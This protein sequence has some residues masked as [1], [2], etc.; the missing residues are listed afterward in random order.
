MRRRTR[1]HLFLAERGGHAGEGIVL[2]IWLAAHRGSNPSFSKCLAIAPDLHRF[3]FYR[4]VVVGRSLDLDH[5]GT[6]T[7]TEVDQGAQLGPNARVKGLGCCVVL[8]ASCLASCRGCVEDRPTV[9]DAALLA[10]AAFAPEAAA[11]T[12]DAAPPGLLDEATVLPVVGD[13]GASSCRLSYGPA[14]QPFRG[15]AALSVVGNELRLITND[16]GKPRIYP[17][18]IPATAAPVMP[19]RPL[20]FVGMRWPACEIAGAFVYCQGP[21]GM[22]VRSQAAGGEPKQI[23]KSRPGTRIAAAPVGADHAAVAYLD[24]RRTT[25]GD[26]LQAF[27]VLD[28]GEPMRLSDDGA[29]ATTVS[30]LPRGDEPVALYLDVRTAMVPVHARPV[31]RTPDGALALGTDAVVFVGGAPER[32]IDFTTALAGD[33]AYAFVPMP[34]DTLEF[35]MA[36]V[37]IESPPKDD[38]PARWSLYPNGIDPA[39]ITAAPSRDGKGAWIARVRPRQKEPGSPRII[40]LGRVD[41]AG[42][43]ASYGEI[44]LAKAVTDIALV[45]DA[46]GGVWVTYGDTTVTWLERRIC[47]TVSANKNG[48]FPRPAR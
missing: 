32:G 47:S 23:A 7:V 45:E 11:P 26:M 31:R 18:P 38:V 36:T 22:I 42:L 13:A 24:L 17:V 33:R 8:F 21:G 28:V 27:V 34:R 44:A 29:G 16:S 30:F 46:G 20:S 40:E 35:G 1:G 14:E 6:E 48:V 4:E 41:V 9:V 15:P 12:V 19:P 43:F 5:P 25:E 3:Q 2:G 37:P 39:P 10:P